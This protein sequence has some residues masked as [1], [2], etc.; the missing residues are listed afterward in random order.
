MYSRYG[1]IKLSELWITAF[2][3]YYIDRAPNEYIFLP[4]EKNWFV[5]KRLGSEDNFNAQMHIGMDYEKVETLNQVL[6]TTYVE[7]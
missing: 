6:E 3:P 1:E 2:P 5:R 7:K 4:N